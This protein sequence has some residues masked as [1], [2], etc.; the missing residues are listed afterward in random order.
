LVDLA[1]LIVGTMVGHGVGLMVGKEQ[2]NRTSEQI[3]QHTN[4]SEEILHQK[5]F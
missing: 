3:E 2:S 4:T 5:D 1:G